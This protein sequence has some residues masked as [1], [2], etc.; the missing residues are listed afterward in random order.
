[1]EPFLC[2]L[3]PRQCRVDRKKTMG[4][5]GVGSVM[6]IARAAP[7]FW[8]EPCISG[9][10][11]SGTVFFAGCNLCCAVCQNW[12]ISVEGFGKELRTDEAAGVFLRL[13]GKG[14][15]NI[16][17]VTPTPWRALIREALD[18]A[19]R[20]GLRIPTVW[21]TGGYETI[22]AVRS[23]SG[24]VDIWLTDLKFLSP[25]LSAMVADAP[26]YFEKASAAVLEMVSESGPPVF[27]AQGVLRRGT[28]I[29]ILV[30]PDH[31]ED[32]KNILRWM[33]EHL[34]GGEYIVSL[35]SQYTPVYR[36]SEN[37]ALKRRLT[38]FEY[39]DVVKE[40]VSLGVTNGYMQNRR[41]ASTEF[42]PAF[43][44]RGV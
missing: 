43:D 39:Q 11:G 14:V 4:F 12:E 33:A 41:S 22:E 10:R 5:C 36:A 31:R 21:N 27:D 7:H 34:R 37:V 1:M 40:A 25:A 29:R 32:A 44:L 15:H 6:K 26:D 18:I 3:C 42:T 19:R 17:L 30:L 13:A 23:L 28:V 35:M 24:D 38:S 16:N 9:S 8:E 2:T 20:G